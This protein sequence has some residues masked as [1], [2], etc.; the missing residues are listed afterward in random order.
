M[1]ELCVE[2]NSMKAISIRYQ[3]GIFSKPWLR[4]EDYL[5]FATIAY[6]SIIGVL[7]CHLEVFKY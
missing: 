6:I 5:N 4:I 1:R 2:G 7:K 3:I